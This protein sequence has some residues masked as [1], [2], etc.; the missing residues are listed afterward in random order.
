EHERSAWV[1]A[2]AHTR[3]G[4]VYDLLGDRERAELS[5]RRALSVRTGPG[6][7]QELAARY[8]REPYRAVLHGAQHEGH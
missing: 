2:W 6:R 4:I 1:S 8:L 5:Y 3:S 7:A